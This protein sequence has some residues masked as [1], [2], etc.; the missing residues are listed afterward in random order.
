MSSSYYFHP[1]YKCIMSWREFEAL[2]ARLQRA[3]NKTAKVICNEKILGKRSGRIRQIDISIRTKIGT[4]NVLIIV[5]CR[6]RNRK[7]DVQAVEAFAGAMNDVG[8]Q[9]G[10][11]VST[12][13]FSKAAYVI[14]KSWFSYSGIGLS[15]G[16]EE[17][18]VSR[19]T[20]TN[21]HQSTMYQAK[22]HSVAHANHRILRR[23]IFSFIA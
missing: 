19:T 2:V 22:A 17:D 8:A 14:A 9:M 4:E 16:S 7:I 12:S 23:G 10:I 1:C 13:G 21:L 15:L 18:E 20:L 11:M 5:E 3:F 6:M